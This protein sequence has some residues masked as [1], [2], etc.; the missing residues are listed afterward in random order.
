MKKIAT[1]ILV[2][3]LITI[4]TVSGTY[5]FFTSIT[6]SGTPLRSATH[7]LEVIYTGDEDIRG[8]L[9]LVVDKSGGYRRQVSIAL[10]ENS[11]D[12]VAN[13][14]IQVESIDPELATEA[15]TWEIYEID[16]DGLEEKKATGTFLDCGAV[17]ATKSKC[18]SKDRIYMLDHVDLFTKDELNQVAE[19][20]REE[21]Q[22]REY[23]VYI[24]LN[25]Y[26][27]ANEV[28]GKSFTGYIGAETENISGVLE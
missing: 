15:L 1:W 16:S 24:W 14:Y 27:A 7:Q 11:I 26:K 2:L 21:L 23:A 4:I 6:S 12:A 5:A 3:L 10:A 19:E 8:N 22:L 20:L 9:N 17:G 13:M 28:L 25:G 18:T